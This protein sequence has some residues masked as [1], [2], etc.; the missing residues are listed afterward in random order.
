M[1]SFFVFLAFTRINTE[2]FAIKQVNISSSSEREG[3]MEAITIEK[4]VKLD[5]QTRNNKILLHIELQNIIYY[6]GT[7]S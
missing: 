7:P 3:S 4:K 5:E 2:Y 6:L 1:L